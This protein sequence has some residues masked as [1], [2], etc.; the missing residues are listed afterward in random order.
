M[1]EIVQKVA[2]KIITGEVQNRVHD[3]ELLRMPRKNRDGSA[4]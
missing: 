1:P 2:G 4:N 3:F